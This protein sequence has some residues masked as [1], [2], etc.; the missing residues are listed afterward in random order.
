MQESRTGTAAEAGGHEGE[1]DGTRGAKTTL[2][3]P[4]LHRP[5]SEEIQVH[6]FTEEVSL[7]VWSVKLLSSHEEVAGKVV[8]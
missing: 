1:R 4:H 3:R 8:P 7:W 5:V 6:V 2:V